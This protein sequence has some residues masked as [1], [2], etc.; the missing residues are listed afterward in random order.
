MFCTKCGN[1]VADNA[2]FCPKCGT[3]VV[4]DTTQE[5][6][7]TSVRTVEPKAANP[8][9]PSP[10][11][12]MPAQTN[13]SPDNGKDFREFVDNHVRTT[14]KFKSADDLLKNGKPFT[15]LWICF[16]VITLV[17]TV[18]MFHGGILG[19]ILCGVLF[20]Y[21]AAYL[22]G[23]INYF[24]L[25]QKHCTGKLTRE[26]DLEDLV[27]FLNAN[28]QFAGSNLGEWGFCGQNSF[29][30]ESIGCKFSKKI[31]AIITFSENSVSG[32]FYAIGSR[33][34]NVTYYVVITPHGFSA[35]G[36]DAGFGRLACLYKAAP[37]IK[38]AMEYYLKSVDLKQP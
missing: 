7:D 4:T 28:L 31:H 16:G 20:G 17:L 35:G 37:I 30:E 19:S 27:K 3:K 10:Q 29:G 36:T 33:K 26:I 5:T 8:V 14:T 6:P 34:G 32:K 18:A 24:R 38:A 13:V 2:K 22:L 15:P 11:T 12:A 9:V 21:V 1:H 23:R 25:Y